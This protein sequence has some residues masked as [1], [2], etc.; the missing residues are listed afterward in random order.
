MSI[1][2]ASRKINHGRDRPRRSRIRLH[3]LVQFFPLL[4]IEGC[5]SLQQGADAGQG[6]VALLEGPV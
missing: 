4:R 1:A 5:Y 3:A 2:L 6:E